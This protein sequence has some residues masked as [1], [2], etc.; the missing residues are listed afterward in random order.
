M[1]TDKIA[2]HLRAGADRQI[3]DEHP[4]KFHGDFGLAEKVVL[5]ILSII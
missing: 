4:S 5:R 3:A 1:T 2:N